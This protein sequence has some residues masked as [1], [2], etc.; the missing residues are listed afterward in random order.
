[1]KMIETVAILNAFHAYPE[2]ILFCYT[3]KIG[4]ILLFEFISHEFFLLGVK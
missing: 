1:M 3:N 4:L 2:V